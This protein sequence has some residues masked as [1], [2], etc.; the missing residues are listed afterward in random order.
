MWILKYIDTLMRDL[1]LK[2]NRKSNPITEMFTPY[3]PV[4]YK[5]LVDEYLATRAKKDKPSTDDEKFPLI[6]G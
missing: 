1:G 5:G 2:V 4:E 6:S 3:K